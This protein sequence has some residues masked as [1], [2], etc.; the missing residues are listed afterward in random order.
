MAGFTIVRIVSGAASFGACRDRAASTALR[1][2]ARSP[3]PVFFTTR[4]PCCAIDGSTAVISWRTNEEADSRVDYSTNSTL[5]PAETLAVTNG[6]FVTEHT[7]TLTGL[8][9]NATYYFRLTSVDRS[10]NAT[11]ALAPNFTVPGPTMHDTASVDFL[12]GTRGVTCDQTGANS[13]A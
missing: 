8:T 13:F 7:V 1:N 11:V 2:S 3:S 9:A 6:A 4:P 5:P 12:A 10:G